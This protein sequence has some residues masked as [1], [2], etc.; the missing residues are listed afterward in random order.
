MKKSFLI[1]TML[2]GCLSA[3]SVNANPLAINPYPHAATSEMAEVDDFVEPEVAQKILD[4]AIPVPVKVEVNKSNILSRIQVPKPG[5]AYFDEVPRVAKDSSVKTEAE[6][7]DFEND[8]LDENQARFLEP[9]DAVKAMSE[10]REVLKTAD[11][12]K[13]IN[14]EKPAYNDEDR[15]ADL[16]ATIAE[17]LQVKKAQELNRAALAQIEQARQE[18]VAVDAL[19]V[20]A[21]QEADFIKKEAEV[22][23]AAMNLEAVKDLEEARKAALEAEMLR[24]KAAADTEVL[25]REA[26]SAKQV[27]EAALREAEILKAKAMEAEIVKNAAIQEAEAFEITKQDAEAEKMQAAED[28]EM[29]KVAALRDKAMQTEALDQNAVIE[30]QMEELEIMKRDTAAQAEAL[31]IETMR[32]KAMQAEAQEEIEALKV[33]SARAKAM[34]AEALEQVADVKAEVKKIEAMKVQA[35]RETKAL[36]IARDQA[37]L[38]A[39]DFEGVKGNSLRVSTKNDGAILPMRDGD[40][41]LSELDKVLLEQKRSLNERNEQV[42][43]QAIES[44]VAPEEIISWQ[45]SAVVKAVDAPAPL[46]EQSQVQ[47][48]AVP[49]ANVRNAPQA[50]KILRPVSDNALRTSSDALLLASAQQWQVEE[51]EDLQKVLSDWTSKSGAELIWDADRNYK[52]LSSLAVS[53]SFEVAVQSLLDQYRDDAVRPTAVLHVDPQTQKRSLVI[54]TLSGV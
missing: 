3:Y 11:S 4:A 33:E 49:E 8:Q 10:K 22:N 35:F 29:L 7:I 37:A 34:Q 20:I 6:T 53:G 19:K 21:K 25:I 9:V 47:A 13:S 36:E 51:G 17:Q 1:S 2:I 26:E 44:S 32:A 31:K 48:Q 16:E 12:L 30:A 46:I 40:D 24:A 23:A 18:Q 54:R 52:S 42:A 45:S 15:R 50:A 14:V 27:K 5:D 28:I 43:S 41:Q 38:K 39:E